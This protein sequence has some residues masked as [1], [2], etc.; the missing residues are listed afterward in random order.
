MCTSRLR[1]FF[2]YKLF[3][4]LIQVTPLTALKFA[5]LSVLA[6]IPKG[7]INIVTGSGGEIGQALADHP[8]VRKI[9][10]TGSTEIGAQVMAR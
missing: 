10:F 8:H 5:E 4:P 6:G 9:A 2:K 7:V 3:K 1:Y